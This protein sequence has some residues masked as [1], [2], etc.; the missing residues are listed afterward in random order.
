[1]CVC[2]VFAEV[3]RNRPHRAASRGWLLRV[4]GGAPH[5]KM[6]HCIDVVFAPRLRRYAADLGDRQREAPVCSAFAEVRRWPGRRSR[7]SSRLLRVSG[8]APSH[9]LAI[10]TMIEFAPSSRGAPFSTVHGELWNVIASLSRRCA[11]V[12]CWGLLRVY[13]GTPSSRAFGWVRHSSAPHLRR[14][15]VHDVP[16]RSRYVVCPALA[17]VRR[18][19][20]EPAVA[21]LSGPYPRR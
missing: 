9:L 18:K 12:L 17:E 19:F 4:R 5:W 2:S 11:V 1:M 14:F 3:R 21:L 16:R 20:A 8:S 7:R 10:W 15:A 13:G 6:V